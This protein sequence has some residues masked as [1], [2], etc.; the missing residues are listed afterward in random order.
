MKKIFFKFLTVVI[1]LSVI[2]Q[3]GC[4]EDPTASL[5]ELPAG[6]LPTPVI[7]SLTPSA[8]ALAGVTEITISGSNFSVEPRNNR[9]YFNNQP[10]TVISATATQLKVISPVVISDTVI[11]RMALAGGNAEFS[12]ELSYKL[13]PA[14]S[15]YYPF[16]SKKGEL[17][18]AVTVDANEILYV[19][20]S[21]LG[22]KKVSTELAL[23]DFAPK[24]PETFFRAMTYASD[25]AIYSVRGGVR[26][27]YKLSQGVAPAAFVSSSQGITDNVNSLDFDKSKNV[28]WAGGSTGIIY[29]IT[30]TKNVKKYNLTGIVNSVKVAGSSLFIALTDNNKELIYKMPIVSADS[31]GAAELY[32]DFSTVDTLLKVVDLAVAEDGDLYIGTNSFVDPIYVVHTDKT[33]EVLYPGLINSSVYSLYWGSG[34]Y[35][36]MTNI[37][38]NADATTTNKTVLRIDMQKNGK[39]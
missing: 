2:W 1:F 6:N 15:E 25:N 3:N 17:P 24:G 8:E 38:K 12:N 20:L 23:S 19:S 18:Y 33:V 13:K 31:L 26:G 4:S 7:S 39:H 28:I 10:A 16:D 11:V 14:V 9:V 32:L 21:G 35:L 37:I 30:F 36:Y 22:T 5:Y 27:V 29:R 34:K